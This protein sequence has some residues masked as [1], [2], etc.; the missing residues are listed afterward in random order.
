MQDSKKNYL[1]FNVYVEK[2][3]SERL[4][5]ERGRKAERPPHM[6]CFIKSF[7][8]IEVLRGETNP[9]EGRRRLAPPT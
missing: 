5:L 7:F 3:F 8:L 6:I 1:I 9:R 4:T 2:S